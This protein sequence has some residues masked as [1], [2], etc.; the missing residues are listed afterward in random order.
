MI[1][2]MLFRKPKS[3]ISKI[4]TARDVRVGN[5]LTWDSYRRWNEAKDYF[6]G[7]VYGRGN[8]FID[9]VL[10]LRETL[11]NLEGMR[12]VLYFGGLERKRIGQSKP[13]DSNHQPLG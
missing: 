7:V 11:T 2:E 9:S 6:S 10:W 4:T 1:V 5:V 13:R 12:P 3:E 8:R